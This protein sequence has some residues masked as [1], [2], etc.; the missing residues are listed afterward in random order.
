MARVFVAL[1]PYMAAV[2]TP[3]GERPAECVVE[4]PDGAVFFESAAGLTIEHVNGTLQSMAVHPKCHA[5]DVSLKMALNRR[6]QAR[7]ATSGNASVGQW[8]DNAG[9]TYSAGYQKFSGNNNVPAD[10]VSGDG[11]ILYYFIG[12]ENNNDG[13]VNILQPV[14]G[15]MGGEWTL[16]SWACCPS[17]ISTTSRT[18]SGLRAGDVIEG[19]IERTD[20]STWRVDSTVNGQTT[21][22]TPRVGSYNYVWADV[23]LEI[24]TINTCNQYS[25]GTV[26]FTDMELTGSSGE[27]VMPSW[28]QPA[29]T[30]CRGTVDIL[31]SKSIDI[32]HN[33]GSAP[34]PFPTPSPSPPNPT[35]SPAPIPVPSPHTGCHAISTVASD[36]WCEANCSAGYCPADMCKC[37][38]FTV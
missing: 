34:S 36:E 8:M 15:W 30:E 33:G 26:H 32:Y 11:Q 28:T 4:I 5:D 23:T 10:P 20:A 21:T 27:S 2:P 24:Y 38:A 12:L 13:P 9:F 17:N 14:L 1:L 7:L 29:G 22:L 35:P 31:D 25:T 16:A 18:I 19:N 3:Q 37:D 6:A